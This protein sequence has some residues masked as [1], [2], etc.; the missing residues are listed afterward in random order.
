MLKGYLITYVNELIVARDCIEL[1]DNYDG[2]PHG[3]TV[4]FCVSSNQT[5]VLED[6]E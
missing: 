5:I 2:N 1:P 4:P 3:N 6:T